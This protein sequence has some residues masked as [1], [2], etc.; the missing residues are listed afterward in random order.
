MK[1]TII[2]SLLAICFAPIAQAAESRM[3]VLFCTGETQAR[4]DGA[5]KAETEALLKVSDS[6]TY[7]EIGLVG[8]GY[9]KGRPRKLSEREIN[10]A[11]T[12]E[13]AADRGPAKSAQYTLNLYTGYLWVLENKSNGEIGTL[14]NG[15]CS[16]AEPLVP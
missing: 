15:K 7:I 1:H 3:T 2:V 16:R 6:Q 8:Q 14:F 13:S 9:A 10:S 12:L 5:P 11:F 4:V